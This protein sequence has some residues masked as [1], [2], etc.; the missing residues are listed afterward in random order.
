VV[1]TRQ[2]ANFFLFLIECYVNL[3]NLLLLIKSL[4][5]IK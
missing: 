3:T 5:K 2:V 4:I 1:R